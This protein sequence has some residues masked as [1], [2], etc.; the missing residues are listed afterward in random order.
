MF[1]NRAMESERKTVAVRGEDSAF[2][3]VVR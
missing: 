2:D 1:L 3:R